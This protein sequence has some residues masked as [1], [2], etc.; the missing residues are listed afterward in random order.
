MNSSPSW[1]AVVVPS[2]TPSKNAKAGVS[3][4]GGV[5]GGWVWV[6]VVVGVTHLRVCTHARVHVLHACV[7]A[8]NVRVC[9]HML[10][11][12]AHGLARVRANTNTRMNPPM[13]A[14]AHTPYGQRA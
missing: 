6:W 14:R 2:P 7:R 4:L 3:D 13:R 11:E 12:C 9:V 8:Y 10:C 5:E 1:C